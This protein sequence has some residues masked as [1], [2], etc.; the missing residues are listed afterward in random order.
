MCID[1]EKRWK[2]ENP[3]TPTQP[4]VRTY[5]IFGTLIFDARIL[6]LVLLNTMAQYCSLLT[7]K[8]GEKNTW[9]LTFSGRRITPGTA[10]T[11]SAAWATTIRA[12]YR[13]VFPATIFD[14]KNQK[15]WLSTQPPQPTSWD[16]TL[17]FIRVM[18]IHSIPSYWE[19]SMYG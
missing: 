18:P 2:D 11:S 1:G 6:Y 8:A 3:Q 13:P 9:L 5:A 7:R 12:G 4:A 17:W 15:S 14:F 16:D 19:L 10:L